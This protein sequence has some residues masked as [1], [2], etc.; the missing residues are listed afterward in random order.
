MSCDGRNQIRIKINNDYPN[1]AIVVSENTY[2]CKS[3]IH[4]YGLNPKLFKI[5]TRP[6]QLYGVK[7]DTPIITTYYKNIYDFIELER[8]IYER[9]EN[10][11]YIDY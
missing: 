10:V 11:K 7:R 1:G 4:A 3:F 9:F 2:F 6:D 5:A 8:V